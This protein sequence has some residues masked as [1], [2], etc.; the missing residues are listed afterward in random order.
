MSSFLKEFFVFLIKELNDIDV[1]TLK[2]V[3]VYDIMFDDYFI[4]GDLHASADYKISLIQTT[5][6]KAINFVIKNE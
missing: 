3:E 2:K 1:A 5:L 4:N 6:K